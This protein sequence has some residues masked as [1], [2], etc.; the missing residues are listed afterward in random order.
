MNRIE[1]LAKMENVLEIPTNKR[2][3]RWYGDYGIYEAKLHVSKEDI[4][5]RIRELNEQIEHRDPIQVE[6]RETLTRLITVE[7]ALNVV[8]AIAMVKEE[9]DEGKIVLDA[10]DF[11]EVTFDVSREYENTIEEE[12]LSYEN[13]ESGIEI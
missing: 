12:I 9:Y 6:I 5:K 8:D 10:D 1:M 3:T 4:K 7:N 11:S 13:Q 2:L